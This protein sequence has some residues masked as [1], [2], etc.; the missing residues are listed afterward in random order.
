M[1]TINRILLADLA[2][3]FPLFQ[4]SVFQS[5]SYAL[6]IQVYVNMIDDRLHTKA[7]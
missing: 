1:L 3:P 5:P 2:L 7:C 4:H 6:P